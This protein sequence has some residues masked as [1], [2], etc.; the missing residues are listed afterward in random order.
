MPLQF[1]PIIRRRYITFHRLNGRLLLVL[2]MVGNI[3]KL[4]IA[5]VSTLKFCLIINTAALIVADRAFGGTLTTQFA[6]IN[7][8]ISTTV[9]T[10]KGYLAIRN[11]RID[12]HRSWM[13]RTWA[14]ASAVCILL[15]TRT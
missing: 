12:Q 8:A 5:T 3:S 9:S 15:S 1:L 4:Y 14:Y 10:T 13:L 2:L 6:V 11:L 7:L